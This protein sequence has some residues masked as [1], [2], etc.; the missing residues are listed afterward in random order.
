MIYKVVNINYY[1]SYVLMVWSIV[2]KLDIRNYCI[3][4][5]NR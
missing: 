1:S 2:K 5:Y 4:V 3:E